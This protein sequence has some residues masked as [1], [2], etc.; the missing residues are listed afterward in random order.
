MLASFC[1]G[2][3]NSNSVVMSDLG[4]LLLDSRVYRGDFG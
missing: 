2:N 1:K 3:S 4:K